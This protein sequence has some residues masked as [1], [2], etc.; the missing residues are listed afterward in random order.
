MA[1]YGWTTYDPRKGGIHIVNDT[2]NKIDLI[3][4]YAK[5]VDDGNSE[6]W[7]LEVEALPRAD[8]HNHQTSTIIFYLGS[9]SPNSRIRCGLEHKTFSSQMEIVCEDTGSSL[10]DFK[11]RISS[12][13][14]YKDALKTLSVK[15][16]RVNENIIW[17]A[18]SIF[19][20]ELEDGKHML[21]DSPG[22]GNLHYVQGS[23]VGHY[24]FNVLFSPKLKSSA[25]TANRLKGRN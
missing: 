16:L 25:M 7:G 14:E 22:T 1:G 23:F 18:K 8:S 10:H 21:Q 17:Q 5:L 2:V 24:K 11:L 12:T 19:T 3:V 15:S 4:Q 20:K 13:R 6:Y 9:E